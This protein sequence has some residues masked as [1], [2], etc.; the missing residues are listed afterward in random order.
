MA[1][2][3]L[4]VLGVFI[5]N[6]IIAI[7][8]V[9]REKRDIAAT[10]A[11]LLVLT[12]IP[13]VGFIFY[14][15][16]GK[17]ISQEKI[18]DLKTQER[19]GLAQLVSLQKEQWQEQE[20][21]PK[22]ILTVESRQVTKLFLETDEAILTKHNQVTLY[23]DGQEKFAA[24]L[25]DI[26]AAKKH[27]HVEYYAIFSDE[28]GTKLKQ[29]LITVAKR[30]VKVK[31]IYDSLGSRGQR[32][33][34][35]KDLEKVGGQAEPFFG[36]RRSP[37]HSPR[38]NYRAHRKLVIIDG[39]IGY[40]GGFNVGDQYLGKSKYFGNWRDT[41]LRIVG[42]AVIA[43][44][45]RFFMD[46][47]AT[48]KGDKKRTKLTYAD[49]YFPLS[50]VRG[51]T[52][53]QI[54]SSGPDN[55]NEAIKLGY[56][57]LISSANKTIDIQ[58][59]YL[60]PDDS[61]YEALSVA[62]LSGIKVRIMIPSKPDHPFVYRAT[63]YFAKALLEKGVEIYQ[64][65]DGFLHSKTFIVDDELASVGSANVDF[66]SF[67]LNFETNA[68]CYDRALVQ[69]LQASFEQDLA[70]CSRLDEAHFRQQS[71]WLRFKQQFSRLL[72]PIL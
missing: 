65:E 14:L 37:I 51:T 10:W 66:R 24:L 61:I 29:A 59:P 19:T 70:K 11:W 2:I 13:V 72:A 4:V 63:Q 5:V 12:L 69:K 21:M 50:S 67:K 32:H 48:I 28:I 22:E 15:F 45:S 33:G 52:S 35:F 8:T 60:I 62:A 18:F 38:F 1:I 41:H 53:I 56:L 34:F 71:V 55:E 23:T 47:N 6:D 43:L 20:L 27:V 42:N 9:F 36:H 39:E 68:F 30:G 17:K 46:W 44:Q 64:Y 31:V 26:L 40:I 16:A 3:N 58:T 7:I 25:A 49:S 57:K 54:V